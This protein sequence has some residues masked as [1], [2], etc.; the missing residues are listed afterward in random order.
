MITT[1]AFARIYKSVHRVMKESDDA[2]LADAIRLMQDQLEGQEA[3]HDIDELIVILQG[4]D[5]AVNRLQAAI[6]YCDEY[7]RE[8]DEEEQDSGVDLAPKT[9]DEKKE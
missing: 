8:G 6:D 1:S 2:G 4:R 5:R 3:Q 9:R 7:P